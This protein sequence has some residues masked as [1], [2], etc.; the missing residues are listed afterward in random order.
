ME[1]I[2]ICPADIESCW[3]KNDACFIKMKSGKVWICCK[4]ID[5]ETGKMDDYAVFGYTTSTKD[6]I[7]EN[8][9]KAIISLPKKK[10]GN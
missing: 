3:E 7:L 1:T 4:N 6:Y 2:L 9:D 5:V 8:Q 10:R